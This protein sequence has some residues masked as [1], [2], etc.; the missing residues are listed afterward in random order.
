MKKDLTGLSQKE[1]ERIIFTELQKTNLNKEY[2][3][4]VLFLFID[5]MVELCAWFDKIKELFIL[6][7]EQNLNF[8]EQFKFNRFM[9]GDII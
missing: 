6:S 3:A 2:K 1:C 5:N 9:L 7:E 4:D 8:I